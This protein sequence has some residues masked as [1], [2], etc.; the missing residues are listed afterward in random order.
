MRLKI[1]KRAVWTAAWC[2]ET[3]AKFWL[4]VIW[5]YRPTR[6]SFQLLRFCCSAVV[7]AAAVADDDDAVATQ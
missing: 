7:D 5:R 1:S 6:T 2:G 3:F 4:M